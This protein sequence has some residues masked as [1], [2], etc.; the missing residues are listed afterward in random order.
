M[1]LSTFGK[2]FQTFLTSH[3]ET[4]VKTVKQGAP[5]D[6]QLLGRIGHISERQVAS[7]RA[8]SEKLDKISE[9]QETSDRANSEKLD[10]INQQLATLMETCRCTNGQSVTSTNEIAA[11]NQKIQELQL[12]FEQSEAK[13][14]KKSDLTTEH[15]N[16]VSITMMETMKIVSVDNV[17]KMDALESR[18]QPL[19]EFE[20][21]GKEQINEMKQDNIAKM[22]ALESRIQPLEEFETKGKEQISEMKQDIVELEAFDNA[23]QQDISGLQTFQT[24]GNELITGLQ[25]EITTMK[26]SD[27]SAKAKLDE[28]DAKQQKLSETTNELQ[29]SQRGVVAFNCYRTSRLE[30]KLK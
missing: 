4:I 9:R 12:K 30:Y 13:N 20:T 7:D 18:I 3:F 22:D 19:E 10:K 5:A 15:L 26:T 14:N 29:D 24:K 17:A 6:T 28:L 23:I 16:K 11:L 21:K 1:I 2:Q 25:Q 27:I 8:N